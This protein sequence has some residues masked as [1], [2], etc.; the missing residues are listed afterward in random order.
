VNVWAIRTD[1]V[2]D[3]DGN[4]DN[5]KQ[6]AKFPKRLWICL[7]WHCWLGLRR[8]SGDGG[9]ENGNSQ[10]KEFLKDFFQNYNSINKEGLKY[11]CFEEKWYFGRVW[12]I[13]IE[14]NNS[15]MDITQAKG[16]NRKN[17]KIQKRLK[18]DFNGKDN[19]VS[20]SKRGK[21]VKVIWET[22]ERE[23]CVS[24]SLLLTGFITKW[25]WEFAM[26]CVKTETWIGK[27]KLQ[28]DFFHKMKKTYLSLPSGWNTTLLSLSGVV[29]VW[30]HFAITQL[31]TFTQIFP[32]SF[33]SII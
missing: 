5:P 25:C 12:L 22:S 8:W 32:N 7:R 28:F 1:R 14:V 16:E 3:T 23:N 17:W 30:F 29:Y 33:I 20:I 4:W 21:S 9:M 6:S 24:I 18:M 11:Y 31:P 26:I 27:K 13:F 10:K 19:V 15:Y 2:W